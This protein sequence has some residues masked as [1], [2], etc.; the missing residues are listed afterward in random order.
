MPLDAPSTVTPEKVS[1]SPGGASQ[2]GSH[3]LA[4]TQSCKRL[5]ALRYIFK[6]IGVSDPPWR[7]IGTLVH[8]CLAYHYAARMANPPKWLTDKSLDQALAETGRGNP[9]EI[10]QSKAVFAYYV[11]HWAAGD[12]WQPMFVE[13]EFFATIG[14][15][16]PG[17]PDSSLDSEVISIRPDLVVEANGDLW[18]VDHKTAGGGWNSDRLARWKEDGEYLLHWQAML[19]LHVLRAALPHRNVRGFVIQRVKRTPPYDC[20]RNPLRIP[21]LAYQQVPR[22][23]RAMALE[24]RRIKEDLAKGI[25]PTPNFAACQGRYGACDYRDLCAADNEA[26]KQLVRQTQYVQI[27]GMTQSG[28]NGA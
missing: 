3:Q 15:L 8:L 25:A 16:D 12:T 5:Y 20:D 17:G 6:L 10:E 2:R 13:K 9:Q 27:G 23:A 21:V 19:Y 28:G 24:E 4:A 18:I 7:M 14:Q 1:A 26:M 22:A 11:Q